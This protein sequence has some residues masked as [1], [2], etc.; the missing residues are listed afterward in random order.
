MVARTEGYLP[1][2]RG[3]AGG[4]G[5]TLPGCVKATLAGFHAE[6]AEEGRGAEKGPPFDTF[7]KGSVSAQVEALLPFKNRYTKAPF[8]TWTA[9]TEIR[10]TVRK[11][12][13][14]R[15]GR[16]SFSPP[17]DRRWAWSGWREVS[18]RGTLAFRLSREAASRPP[19]CGLNKRGVDQSAQLLPGCDGLCERRRKAIISG[20]KDPSCEVI[21]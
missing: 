4:G 12:W 11:R 7:P 5:S 15:E 20:D 10:L 17:N 19:R 8:P 18:V 6:T 3:G 21:R 14:R 2:S 16:T 13:G 1:S 9:V